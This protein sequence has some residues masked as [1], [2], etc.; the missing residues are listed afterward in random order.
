MNK[1]I[2]WDM[3]GTIANLYAVEGW[4]EA[5]RAYNPLPYL[6]AAPMWDMC[7]LCKILGKLRNNG[8]TIGI[9][10]WLSKE[11]THEYDRAVREAKRL[12]LEATGLWSCMD[13][14]HMV[15]YGTPKHTTA[16]IRHGI[17]IDDNS[18]VRSAWEKYGGETIDPT[19]V[20]ILEVLANMIEEEM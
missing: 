13:E 5:L 9:I 10:T 4:L 11:S 2:Y 20:D 8:Y 16:K 1:V 7:E 19:E 14:I 6:E 17:L 18:D 15:K 12:W 3:D